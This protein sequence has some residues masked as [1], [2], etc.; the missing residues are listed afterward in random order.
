MYILIKCKL[1]NLRDLF[2]DTFFKINFFKK[3]ISGSLSE[4]QAVR[5][6][7]TPNVL[8]VLIMGPSLLQSLSADDKVASNTE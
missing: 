2:L 3:C 5:I 1:G 4:C 6:Q 7:L 8:S